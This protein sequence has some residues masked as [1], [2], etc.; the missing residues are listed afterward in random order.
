[1]GDKHLKEDIRHEKI[2]GFFDYLN[3]FAFAGGRVV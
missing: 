1:L 3:G 2:S